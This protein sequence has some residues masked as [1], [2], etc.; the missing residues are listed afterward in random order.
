M[1]LKKEI[2]NASE[3][4]EPKGKDVF[5]RALPYPKLTY[6]EFVFLQIG[7]IRKRMWVLSA[8]VILA[9]VCAVCVIPD[10]S[11]L[12]LWIISSLA[13]FLAVFTSSEISRSCI[14]G[15]SEIEAGCRFA[16]PQ[17]TGARMLILG[18]CNF[19]V[20]SAGTVISGI[21][22]PYGVALS[23]LYILTPYVCVCGISLAVFGKT[24]GHDGVYISGGLALAVSVLGIV[25]FPGGKLQSAVY[26][27]N[28]SEFLLCAAGTV[29][30]VIQIKKLLVGKDFYYG[31]EN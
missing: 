3:P 22:S 11:A 7:Y 27:V 28:L 25:L 30:T 10:R 1:N 9:G 6:P 14:F 31:T 23:A 2:Y 19:A 21:F 15:M 4:P 18:V 26:F 12:V 20:I 17:L 8:A 5:L 16:L 13:P 29:F 24:R